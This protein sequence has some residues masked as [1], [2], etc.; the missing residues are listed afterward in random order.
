MFIS[1]LHLFFEV[2]TVHYFK[3]FYIFEWMFP[4]IISFDI[5]LIVCHYKECLTIF[6]MCL[7]LGEVK[8][9]DVLEFPHGRQVG[10]GF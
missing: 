7:K 8:I 6:Q 2:V 1:H 10:E 5:L 4:F 9:Q 3:L